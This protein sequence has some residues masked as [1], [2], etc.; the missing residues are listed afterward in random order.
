MSITFAPNSIL[1]INNDIISMANMGFAT[2]L[3]SEMFMVLVPLI[4]F[5]GQFRFLFSSLVTSLVTECYVQL[6]KT[7]GSLALEKLTKHN[8][9]MALKFDKIT[10]LF[11]W[12]KQFVMLWL[13][14]EWGKKISMFTTLFIFYIYF[15]VHNFVQLTQHLLGSIDE[16]TKK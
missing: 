13:L 10:Q 14:Q 11:I 5:L 9:F 4:R 7:L 8:S 16:L 15:K 3:F 1:L 6:W 2:T 12:V